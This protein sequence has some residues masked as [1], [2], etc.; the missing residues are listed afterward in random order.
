[1]KVFSLTG[2]GG[3][4]IAPMSDAVLMFPDTETPRIQ[5]AHLTALHTICYLIEREMFITKQ[6]TGSALGR[7]NQS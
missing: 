5:E 2:R 4:R 3:G 6:K 1:M 7:E